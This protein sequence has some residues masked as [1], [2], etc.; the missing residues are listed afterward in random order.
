MTNTI[1][2][3]S[4][5][6]ATNQH[7]LADYIHHAQ[8]VSQVW[9][10]L[11]GFSWQANV[12][13]TPRGSLRFV[14]YGIKLHSRALPIAAQQFDSGYMKFA[15]AYLL[16]SRCGYPS[17]SFRTD[18]LA[19]QILEAALIEVD[20]YADI[21]RLSPVHL[22]KAVEIIRTRKKG[23]LSAG[24]A[25]KKLVRVV[26]QHN[27]TS[28]GLKYWMHPFSN[29]GSGR[30]E[31][32]T[33]T[34]LPDDDALLAFAEIFSRGYHGDL[35]DEAVYVSSITAILLS[36]PMRI[37]EKMRLRLSSL[38]FETDKHG[39][40][41]WYLHYYSPKN[42]K[43]VTKGIPAVMADHCREAFRRLESVTQE[44]RKLA[45]Y[46]ESGSV[47][48]YPHPGVPDIPA[49]QI[50]TPREVMKALGRPSMGS[51]E[52]LMKQLTSNYRLSGWT[53]DTLWSTI[54]SYN[55]RVNP[56][57]PYQVD[58][59]LYPVKPPKMS[60]SLLCFL[61]NQLAENKTTCPVLLAPSNPHY[62]AIRVAPSKVSSA[63]GKLYESFLSRYGYPDSSIRS[64]QLRHFLNTA[65][66]EA[67]VSIET[68]TQWSGRASVKQTREYIH[69][70]PEREARKLSGS[71][72]PVADVTPDPIT[73]AEY[74]V[75]KKGP[76]ITT[77][78]G[79]CMH[80]WTTSACQ[81][82]GDCLNCSDL[83]HCKGHKNSLQAVKV[84]RDQVAENL[85]ATLNEIESGNRPATRW[86]DTHTRYLERLNQIVAMHENPDIPDGSPVQMAGKDFT[87]AK[88]VL[89]KK[90]P[91][92]ALDSV[93]SDHLSEIYDDD[94]RLC[95]YEMIG[96]N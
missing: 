94:L 74:D 25:L 49:D 33:K 83:L 5:A 1:Q 78:Y 14:K 66:K 11:P 17:K 41:Q 61:R 38:K 23:H 93:V 69:Q 92:P 15:K 45:L 16:N 24:V 3:Q 18:Y 54:H 59:N 30:S 90:Q 77:R 42:K 53:L 71:L 31:K 57:F 80:A 46:L 34:S 75:R 55:M 35:D 89:V 47:S 37:S 6:Q 67:G 82:S 88:R 50:M 52:I 84:E 29:K 9:K 64:H 26:A 85:E 62:F 96:T 7:K 86:V 36:V 40:I 60:E 22:E 20:G 13:N 58:P 95:L 63:N 32:P 72:I 65:A 4:K 81:K 8:Y 76:I 87:H 21:T 28:H 56:F 27:I 12:W 73:A 2:F 44:G 10:D 39:V 68:I 51:A 70:D 48:F 43:M 19:V 91:Q 79:I